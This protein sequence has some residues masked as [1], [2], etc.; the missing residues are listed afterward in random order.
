MKI[1]LT[2]GGFFIVNK[3][4]INFQLKLIYIIVKPDIYYYISKLYTIYINHS[5]DYKSTHNS[6]I[7]PIRI[8]NN[9]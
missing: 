5:L 2:R 8:K 9:H 1:L 3:A 7:R 6:H 4:Y